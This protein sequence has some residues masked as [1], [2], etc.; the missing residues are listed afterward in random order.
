MFV[1][2]YRLCH[3]CLRWQSLY[4]WW[5]NALWAQCATS[6]APSGSFQRVA[7]GSWWG[8]FEGRVH[9]PQ[10]HPSRYSYPVAKAKFINE[11]FYPAPSPRLREAT[12]FEACTAKGIYMHR[13]VSR[14]IP[15]EY[16][17]CAVM[18]CQYN[19]L[20]NIMCIVILSSYTI[21]NPEVKCIA[22]NS[23]CFM[24]WWEE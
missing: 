18:Q 21:P 3:S 15:L 6:A 13:N 24:S 9:A 1:P 2:R 16:Y 22:C 8:Q 11:G 14:E 4:P 23:F 20:H 7:A 12:R 10:Q 17:T 19:D 5:V